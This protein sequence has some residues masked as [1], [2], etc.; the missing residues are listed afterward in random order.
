M[1]DTINKRTSPVTPRGVNHLVLNVRDVEES[2][3][4]WSDLLGFK[5]VGKLKPR[6]DGIPSMNMQFYS[7]VVDGV[8][9]HDIALVER[10]GLNEPPSEWSMFDGNLAVNH[11]AITYPDRDSW[12]EQVQ[13]LKDQGVKMNL[14][15]DHGMTHSVY[16]NDPNGYGVEVLYELP[17]EVWEHDIDGALNYAN[18]LPEEDLLVDTTDYETNFAK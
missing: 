7:G 18:V 5:Q 9:H 10:E 16:I 13:Y 8:N 12:L 4:F 11:I 6:T 15:V 2:H 17:A 3:H 14:R 1:T